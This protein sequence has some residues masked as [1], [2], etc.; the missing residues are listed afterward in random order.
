[1]FLI[2]ICKR[3]LPFKP[4]ET[5]RDF[6]TGSEKHSLFTFLRHKGV[7]PTNNHAEQSIRHMVIF[8]KLS[9]DTRS[10]TAI[11][12]HSILP[13]LLQTARRKGASPINFF[14]T[15][16]TSDTQTAKAALYRNSS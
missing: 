7:A 14:H 3:Y 9:F 15:L 5:L 12:T 10:Q 1:M 4:A 8:R 6:L 2:K 13:S 16:F 11:E